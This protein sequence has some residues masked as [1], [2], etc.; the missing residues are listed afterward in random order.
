MTRQRELQAE[1][2]PHAKL[3]PGVAD[4]VSTLRASPPA[5]HPNENIHLALATS[6]NSYAFA[7]KTQHLP[8]LFEQF[9]SE[10]RVLGD[11]PRIP[12]GRGKP[13]PDIYLVAL[14]GINR[15]IRREGGQEVTPE[16]CLVFED[17]VPG[18]EAG[19]RAGMRVVWV[20]HVGLLEEYKGREGMVLAGLMGEAERDHGDASEGV[21]GVEG[22]GMAELRTTLE[23]FDYGRY[24]IVAPA[25]K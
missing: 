12:T 14:E 18:V 10:N 1:L 23:G 11:D 22:D 6:S 2:F 19:R 5:S 7:L 24:G 13:S 3:L 9:P 21:V 16:E 8:E 20:P 4:L 25:G 15:G 17:A